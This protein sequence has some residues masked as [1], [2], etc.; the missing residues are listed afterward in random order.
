MMAGVM[1]T[2][3]VETMDSMMVGKLAEKTVAH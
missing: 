3:S 1:A 2:W